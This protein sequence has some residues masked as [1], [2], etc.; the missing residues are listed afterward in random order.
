MSPIAHSP[1]LR[2]YILVLPG[3]PDLL[4]AHLLQCSIPLSCCCSSAGPLLNTTRLLRMAFLMFSWSRPSA[5]DKIS[6]KRGSYK[7]VQHE[8]STVSLNSWGAWR[9]VLLSRDLRGRCNCNGICTPGMPI[10]ENFTVGEGCMPRL[11]SNHVLGKATAVDLCCNMKVESV[12]ANCCTTSRSAM[13]MH[14]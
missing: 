4:A 2:C 1:N 9:G 3:Q 5:T 12:I 8:N 7:Q 6:P 14:C 10:L 11:C 13:S